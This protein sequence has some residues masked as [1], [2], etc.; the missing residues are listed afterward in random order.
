VFLKSPYQSHF[1][2]SNTLYLTFCFFLLATVGF[3]QTA[4]VD[5]TQLLKDQERIGKISGQLAR[6]RDK[7][8]QLE[9]EYAQRTVDKQKAIAQAEASAN[10]NRKAAEAL[11]NDAAN[12]SKARKAEKRASRA[13]RDAKSIQRADKNLS[14]VEKNIRKLKNQI[15]RDEKAL[16]ELQPQSSPM[17]GNGADTLRTDSV[18]ADS[19]R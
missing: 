1:M 5:S 11:S 16:A 10:D 12:T 2:K 3:G 19:S 6:N 7:L 13:R 8:A 18:P 14:H 4:P 17:P 9:K 15:A